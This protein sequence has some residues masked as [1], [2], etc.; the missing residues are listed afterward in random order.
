GE[1]AGESF[2]Y[3]IR[4]SG[5]YKSEKQ[6]EDIV[7]KSFDNGQILR[8]KDVATIELGSQTYGGY[9]ELN[10][11]P[12]VAMAIYQT[13]GSNAQDII[14]EIKAELKKIEQNLPEGIKYKINQDTNEFL[15]ASID[16]VVTTLIEAFILVFLVVYIFLQ[17]F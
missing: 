17:D 13:P 6:Y 5:K 1:N 3:I 4:Y 16:K 12:A 11:M 2:Q 8:L 9:S 14:N 7:I 10:G 15:E